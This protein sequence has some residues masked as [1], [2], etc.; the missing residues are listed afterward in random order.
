MLGSIFGE[1]VVEICNLAIY[2]TSIN[3]ICDLLSTWL[4]DTMMH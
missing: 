4:D 3:R 1:L 2:N